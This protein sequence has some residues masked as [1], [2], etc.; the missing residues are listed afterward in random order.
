MKSIFSKIIDLEIPCHLVAQ[1]KNAIAFMDINPIKKGHVLIVPK[2]EVDYLFDLEVKMYNN[3]WL[4]TRKVASALKQTI[5]CQRVGVSVI[6]LEV[7]HAHIHLVPINSVDD[8]NF[9]N[10]ISM[11]SEELQKIAQSISDN[12]D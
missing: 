12:I 1:D 4:F 11:S 7:P 8:M 9:A 3:L 6:G 2:I 10:K 5:A